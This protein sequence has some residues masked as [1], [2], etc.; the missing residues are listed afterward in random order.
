M[1][2]L[3]EN[4]T[5][6]RAHSTV[7]ADYF[8]KPTIPVAYAA[9]LLA[10]A[11]PAARIRALQLAGLPENLLSL[12]RYRASV[13]QIERLYVAIVRAED[14]EMFGFLRRPVPRGSYAVLLRL[15]A[16]SRNVA[17]MIESSSRF[18]AL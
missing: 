5:S 12:R 15:L 13:E 6:A 11:K 3:T 2:A 17:D 16:G 4:E 8:V 9:E 1:R 10:H 7:G 14:D 18:Y